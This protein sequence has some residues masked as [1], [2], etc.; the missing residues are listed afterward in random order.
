[1]VETVADRLK[2]LLESEQIDT[3]VSV[4]AQQTAVS[5]EAYLDQ[6]LVGDGAISFITHLAL[7]LARLVAGNALTNALP[8]EM[9]AELQAQTADWQ[10]A[11]S[12]A[13][14]LEQTLGITFPESEIG[15]L[16]AHI[17]GLKAAA[18]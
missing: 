11:E 5:V 3:A 7:A 10:F 13:A 18:E 16:A 14:Q 12:L 9:L 17:S 8:A 6:P 4:A 1:M 15:F 2:L